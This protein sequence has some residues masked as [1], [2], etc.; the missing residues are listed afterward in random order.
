M[1]SVEQHGLH[2]LL[3]KGFSLLTGCDFAI[4]VGSSQRTQSHSSMAWTAFWMVLASSP[5]EAARPAGGH[6]EPAGAAGV[7]GAPFEPLEGEDD[8]GTATAA[9]TPTRLPIWVLWQ[10]IWWHWWFPL[11]GFGQEQDGLQRQSE[12]AQKAK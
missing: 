1:R 12:A 11:P 4:V 9:R 6:T 8:T 5:S 2:F 7:T 3:S 10:R